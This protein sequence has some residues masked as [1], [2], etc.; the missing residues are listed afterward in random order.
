M[1]RKPLQ[2]VRHHHGIIIKEIDDFTGGLLYRLVTLAARAGSFGNQQFILT[3]WPAQGGYP[4]GSLRNQPRFDRYD[5][6][7]GQQYSSTNRKNRVKPGFFKQNQTTD[8]NSYYH[9]YAVLTTA[10]LLPGSRK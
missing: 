10:G 8:I 2:G 4:S 1:P 7:D 5:Y 6:G 3:G 9:N